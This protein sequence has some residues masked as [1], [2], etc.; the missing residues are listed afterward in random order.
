MR[1][2]DIII[3]AAIAASLVLGFALAVCGTSGGGGR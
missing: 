3:V 2:N 1:P